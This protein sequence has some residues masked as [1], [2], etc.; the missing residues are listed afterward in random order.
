MN[1]FIC[2]TCKQFCYSA[3]SLKTMYDTKCPYSGC[4]GEVVDAPEISK[5]ESQPRSQFDSRKEGL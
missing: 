1:R 5:D 2:T 3:A 4:P